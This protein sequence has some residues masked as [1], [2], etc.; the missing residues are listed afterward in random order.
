MNKLLGNKKKAAPEPVQVNNDALSALSS[1]AMTSPNSTNPHGLQKKKTTRWGR[2]K[3]A[4]EP[5][6][7]PNFSE[8]LPSTEE[9]RT[10]LIMPNL[11]AR[12]SMLREQDDPHS[13]LGKASDDSVLLPRRKS[14]M[15]DFGMGNLGDIAE[16][17]SIN[18]S[19][20]PPFAQDRQASFG[21]EEGYGSENDSALNAAGVMSRARPGEGNTMFGGR[22]KV[23]M[24]PKSGAVSTRSL[25]KA[26]YE[27][28]IGRS[29]FQRYRMERDAQQ[30]D[31]RA[32]EESQIHGGF[33]FGIDQQA[34]AEQDEANHSPANDSGRDLS[35]SPSLSS[36]D[37]KR[38][39]TSTSRSEARSSTAATSVASQPLTSTASAAVTTREPVPAKPELQRSNT[40]TRRLY[41]QGLDQ[42]MQEQ[43][44]TAMSRLNSLH[45]Q[46]AGTAGGKQSPPFLHNSRSVGNL[47]DRSPQPVYALRNQS[48]TPS[49][50]NLT[51]LGSIRKQRSNN[52]SPN[53]GATSSPP[54]SPPIGGGDFD[55]L[56]V[57]NQALDPADRGKATALGAFNKP[58]Q[59][60]DE[61]QYLERQRALQRSN[62]T[63]TTKAAAVSKV[64]MQQ[65]IGRFEQ[66]QQ[67]QQQS[68]DRS[69][70]GASGRTRSRSNS[71]PTDPKVAYNVF[72]KA[73]T[74]IQEQ[75]GSIPPTT[76]RSPLPDTHRTFFGDI[77]ASD[78]EDDED[79]ATMQQS[80]A[81]PDY[82]YGTTHG[83]WQPTVLPAVSEHPGL[84]SETSRGTLYEE[85]EDLSPKP[86][87]TANSKGSLNEVPSN[88]DMTGP[89]SDPAHAMGNMIH[90]LRQRSN[91]S[92]I[93]P[94]DEQDE[95]VVTVDPSRPDVPNMPYLP[96]ENLDLINRRVRSPATAE[97]D[98]RADSTYTA[99]NPW[100]LDES[101][102]RAQH[103]HGNDENRYSEVS[104]IEPTFTSQY[105]TRNP[106]HAAMF[107]ERESEVSH[108][109]SSDDAN[110]VFAWQSEL[111]K[112]THNRD[113]SNATQV[114]RDAFANELAQRQKAIQERLAGVVE[115]NS[116]EASPAPA[117]SGNSGGLKALGMLRSKSSRESVANR[118]ETS[119]KAMKMLGIT[120]AP[121]T[122]DL[123]S[124][125]DNRAGYSLDYPARP[126]ED[127]TSRSSP[128][129][130]PNLQEHEISR[131][132]ELSRAR[133]ESSGSRGEWQ[134]P[135][136]GS[137]SPANAARNRTRS[138]SNSAATSA[139]GRSRSR[140]GTYRDDLQKA[141]AEGT[142]TSAYGL[143]DFIPQELTPRPSPDIMQEQFQNVR[144]RSNSRQAQNQ[145]QQSGYFDSKNLQ[146]LSTGQSGAPS[147]GAGS[148]PNAYTSSN[149]SGFGASPSTMAPAY[150]PSST[151]PPLS[152]SSTPI[153]H[154]RTFSPTGNAIA[155]K[156]SS[157][158][159]RKKTIS[160]SDISEPTLIA[161]TS[162]IDTVDLPEGASLKNGM[163][164]AEAPPIPP[165][166][167]K[168]RGTRRFFG[169]PR[170]ASSSSSPVPQREPEEPRGKTP[171]PWI[172]PSERNA[173]M[174]FDHAAGGK[175]DYNGLVAPR[176]PQT[177]ALSPTVAAPVNGNAP[178]QQ[179]DFGTSGELQYS[180]E[181]VERSS[182]PQQGI[183]MDGGMF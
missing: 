13:K 88:P 100:D 105:G 71:R 64:A 98:S 68:R 168:R 89:A 50:P 138:R 134:Q 24:I 169:N 123:H 22:Q 38:S 118:P 78:S 48:P 21:S 160:K 9:F 108:L 141:M 140:T 106:S 12:F 164:E 126:R 59:Q 91:Q 167:P 84:R 178:A 29:A 174:P 85:D 125:Y 1:P 49:H 93:Y 94:A 99:S 136:S 147:P 181:R 183:S 158:R 176:A 97:T 18:S 102:D 31:L 145:V 165:I 32:S 33:D 151:T 124:Q 17:A 120:G 103:L 86:L 111:R 155:T 107:Q 182:P 10:S 119:A 4:P 2:K 46:R 87:H 56:N 177:V 80:Y 166:N 83:R 121:S 139:Y 110:N 66:Q 117:P 162:T 73:A 92:S 171:D 43:Q 8:L 144:A 69:N 76:E 6:P 130:T 72:Q 70:S 122:R 40:K 104:P 161:S 149:I 63:A 137:G 133:G 152:G 159:L 157:Q 170:D 132:R 163:E 42:H 77:G 75:Q 112:Q 35:H 115:T 58:H 127:S 96:P 23:Y 90:H 175:R 41:E 113:A 146:H 116:R 39:T 51:S 16:V 20:R 47:Q 14:R 25:G 135:A 173:T 153:N 95:A 55:D 26:V 37:K 3:V 143:P 179:F 154:A 65:R 5:K 62:S 36:Y 34:G 114:E 180:P 128:F 61:Q 67:S 142:G 156:S 81:G 148:S 54:V 57:L 131:E 53:I 30:E 82:G 74:Q 19:I 150:V 11:S 129:A 60:F 79:S 172:R 28:D 101:S 45:R 15:M 27:D 109:S 44:S 52:A 7:E